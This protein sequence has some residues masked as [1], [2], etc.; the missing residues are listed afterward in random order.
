MSSGK[1]NK[2]S[3]VFATD[4]QT[5]T[6]PEEEVQTITTIHI[7]HARVKESSLWYLSE[8]VPHI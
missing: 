5:A 3:P 4:W 1:Q 7:G 8:R 6:Q 2:N